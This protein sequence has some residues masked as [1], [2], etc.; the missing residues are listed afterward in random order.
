ME[1]QMN[2]LKVALLALG[3]ALASLFVG[4]GTAQAATY[5]VALSPNCAPAS[6]LSIDVQSYGKW[7]NVARC[8]NKYGV[9]VARLNPRRCAKWRYFN[10]TTW[11][12]TCNNG[13]YGYIY[14]T[15]LDNTLIEK[16]WAI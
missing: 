8:T 6:P 10:T 15:I 13:N 7:V 3:M 2:K 9:D 14:W 1:E 5:E 11:H 4:S 12:N 16:V